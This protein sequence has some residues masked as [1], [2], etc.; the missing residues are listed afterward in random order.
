MKKH[1]FMPVIWGLACFVGAAS[2][3]G[4]EAAYYRQKAE[5]AFADQRYLQAAS[6]AAQ[7]LSENRRDRQMHI[8]LILASDKMGAGRGHVSDL[9]QQALMLYPASPKL[10]AHAAGFYQRNGNPGYAG[11]LANAFE[12]ACRFNCIDY[13]KIITA[14]RQTN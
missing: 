1:G 10:L 9:Y 11:Q 14:E 4:D 8:L 3:F 2:A 7:A 13:R 12:K 6:F 5:Q